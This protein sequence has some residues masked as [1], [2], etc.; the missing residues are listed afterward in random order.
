MRKLM[1]PGYAFSFYL[2]KSFFKWVLITSVV[3]GGI[4]ILFDSLELLRRTQDAEGFS[5]ILLL[6][7]V[8]YRFPLFF[9]DILPFTLFFAAIITFWRLSSSHEVL[10]M[11]ASGVSIWQILTPL[12]SA[13]LLLGAF[14]LLVL[15]P[16]SASLIEK[17]Y[18]LERKYIYQTDAPFALSKSGLWLRE[19]FDNKQM[20]LNAK[21]YN[22]KGNQFSDLQVYIFDKE[23][24]FVERYS[25]QKAILDDQHLALTSGW[26]VPKDGYPKRFLNVKLPTTYTKSRIIE[27]FQD[28]ET[29]N[30]YALKSYG[31]L[32]EESG[33]SATP[34]YM[35]W[36]TLFS[37]CF[38]LSIMVILAATFSLSHSRSGTGVR[39]ILGGI[40]VTFIL[41]FLRDITFALGSAGNLPP[42]LAAWLPVM[43]T[44]FFATTK[45]LYS[46]DG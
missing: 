7:L 18:K 11:R 46:E 34:Y 42:I 19:H 40:T 26:Y 9:Q 30:F 21:H 5:V 20:I 13:T 16:F 39:L 2:L 28:P 37:K 22:D 1:G 25:A 23:D 32:M 15:N 27:S 33:L 6:K 3:F 31:D 36:H 17:Y 12:L 8:L 29:L 14:D 24:Q 43:I 35:Q 41:Y 38:W 45:L 44:V 10:V 4:Y